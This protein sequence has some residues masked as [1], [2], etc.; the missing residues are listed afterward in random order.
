MKDVKG[1]KLNLTK[2]KKVLANPTKNY[3]NQSKGLTMIKVDFGGPN[4]QSFAI[5]KPSTVKNNPYSSPLT[6]SMSELEYK[7]F[8]LNPYNNDLAQIDPKLGLMTGIST[9]KRKFSSK[10]RVLQTVKSLNSLDLTRQASMFEK[11]DSKTP[12]S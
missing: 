11:N 1:S 7:D 12:K 3:H 4:A 2:S 10:H 5:S 8:L 6:T 9:P